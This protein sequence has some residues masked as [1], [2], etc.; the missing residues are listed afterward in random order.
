MITEF[1]ASTDAG[2]FVL[3]L[4]HILFVA[5]VLGSMRR[6]DVAVRAADAGILPVVWVRLDTEGVAER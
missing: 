3:E 5:S 1:K 6:L 4:F 2:S